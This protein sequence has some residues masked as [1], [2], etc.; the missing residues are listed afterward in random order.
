M[1]TLSHHH[2]HISWWDNSRLNVISTL[3]MA[4]IEK[5]QL[6]ESIVTLLPLDDLVRFHA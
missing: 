6:A 4:Q 3:A 2:H 5:E 1:Q